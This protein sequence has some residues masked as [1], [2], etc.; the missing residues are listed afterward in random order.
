MISNVVADK[1]PMGSPSIV[2]VTSLSFDA[3]ETCLT[4]YPILANHSM[5][6][7]RS[8][9]IIIVA[10]IT[11]CANWLLLFQIELKSYEF[12]L[13]LERQNFGI[14]SP[15]FITSDIF[16]PYPWAGSRLPAPRQQ[17][18]LPAK[19]KELT[20]RAN[21]DRYQI[22]RFSSQNTCAFGSDKNVSACF[23][24]IFQIWLLMQLATGT[25]KKV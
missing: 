4:A 22:N 7:K 2:T 11:L 20:A 15:A 3:I 16:N 1:T 21:I 10:T 24:Y 17:M 8:W 6:K 14:S 19:P 25:V 9:Q 18:P 5:Q 13:P 12:P 23:Q